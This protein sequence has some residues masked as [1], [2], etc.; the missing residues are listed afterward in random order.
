MSES[1]SDAAE[2]G[3]PSRGPGA[4]TGLPGLVARIAEGWA[5]LGGLSLLAVVLIN[6]ASV[7]GAAV[8][9]EPV[10]GDFELTEMGICIAAFMFLPYCQMTGANVTADIFTQNAG[11][12]WLAVF[13][14][15]ASTVAALFGALMLWRMYAGMLDQ[16]EYGYVTTILEIPHGWAFVPILASLALLTL[17]ALTTLSEAIRDMRPAR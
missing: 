4:R 1:A 17:C 7:T 5:L 12:R 2:A 11:R 10:P 8:L 15:A 9:N 6:T 3:A 16:L 14:A 13:A